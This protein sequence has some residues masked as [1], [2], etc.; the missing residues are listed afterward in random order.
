MINPDNFDARRGMRTEKR[1]CRKHPDAPILTGWQFI[2][3]G[4][5]G[6]I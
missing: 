6:N 2:H 5:R 1:T 3:N 4:L